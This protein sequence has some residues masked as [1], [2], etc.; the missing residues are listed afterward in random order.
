MLLESYQKIIFK[1][2]LNNLPERKCLINTI[3]AYSFTVAQKNSSFHAALL[4]SCALLPDGIS[5][6][7]AFRFLT[8]VK[9]KKIAGSDLFVWEMER[10]ENLKGKCFFLG[11]TKETLQKI[12]EHA[13]KDYPHVKIESFS[14]AYKPIFDQQECDEMIQ[15]VNSFSPDVLFIGMT[16]PKQETW[17][18]TYF[19]ELNANHICCIGAVFDFYAGNINRCPEWVNKSGF[20]WLYRL[21]KEPGRMWR[22]YLIGNTQFIWLVFRE[23]I[24]R[25]FGNLNSHP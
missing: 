14:P 3:N 22:R 21:I 9:F 13:K 8:G 15:A 18:A 25:I 12:T 10:L 24:I 17:A 20:E 23:K 7:W 19:D 4:K 6:V 16:A 5:I 11:S 1:E 2:P